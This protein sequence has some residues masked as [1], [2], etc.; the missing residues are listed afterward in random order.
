MKKKTFPYIISILVVLLVSCLMPLLLFYANVEAIKFV[1]VLIFMGIYAAVSLILFFVLRFTTKSIYKAA[2]IT[3]IVTL[4][5]QNIGRLTPVL[6]HWIILG[7]FALLI[8]AIAILSKKFLSEEIAETFVPVIAVVLAML[9]IFNTVMSMGR[10]LNK[11]S[12]GD[13]ISKEIDNRFSYL[14]TFKDEDRPLPEDLPNVYFIIVDEYA[15]FNSINKLYNYDN[16]QF[17]AFLEESGFTV[18]TSGTN[19]ADGTLECLADVFNLEVNEQN[20]YRNSS[21]AYCQKKVSDGVL[22]RFAEDWGYNIRAVQT[23]DLIKYKSE[24]KQYGKLWSTTADG[25]LSIE[26]MANPTIYSP[27]EKA[28][29]SVLKAL[30]VEPTVQKGV[31][32][33]LAASSSDPISYLSRDDIFRDNTFTL[34]YAQFPHQP[35]YYD[36]NGN[37]TKNSSKLNDWGDKNMYLGQFKYCTKLLT[38]GIENILENDPDSII[39]LMSDHG[40]RTHELDK[41]PWMKELT[42]K[43]TGDILCAI[44]NQGEEFVDIEGLCGANVITTLVNEVYGYNIPLTQQ[45]EDFYK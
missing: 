20:R 21:E 33:N 11:G 16:S 40:V 37:L 7:I 41:N 32:K 3:T 25:E 27:I 43:D 9:Y 38:E 19:Y 36:E 12:L 44:Y 18:S 39:I 2:A 22:F 24:T 14:S 26:L 31:V 6:N 13:E 8:A 35:F 28:Y 34:C 17:K 23:S 4:I 1:E 45:A 15:G 42:K 5:F 29:N 30:S 10:I